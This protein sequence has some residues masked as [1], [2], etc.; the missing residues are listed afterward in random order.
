MVSLDEPEENRRF[1]ASVGAD[2]VLLSDPSKK[3]AKAY[4]VL[5][6]GGLYA[7]RIT[8]FID[9]KGIIARVDHDVDPST[10]GKDI[11]QALDE[12]GFPKKAAPTD[13]EPP[14]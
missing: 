13:T 12:L 6:F 5:A 11:V 14:S 10:H 8:Y 7:R 9:S 4:D 1:A 3:H 2:F